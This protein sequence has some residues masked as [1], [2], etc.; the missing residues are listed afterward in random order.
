MD[1]RAQ[2]YRDGYR[3]GYYDASLGLC[4]VSALSTWLPN[5]ADGYYDG[6]L[7]YHEQT[8]TFDYEA[9]RRRGWA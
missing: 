9:I 6:R 4:L 5:Y 1:Y 3:A 8:Q 7:A 2:Y